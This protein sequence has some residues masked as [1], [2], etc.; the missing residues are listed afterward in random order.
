MG[1]IKYPWYGTYETK[2]RH[3]EYDMTVLMAWISRKITTKEAAKKIA[4]NNYA[5]VLKEDAF[6]EMVG[7][8]GWKRDEN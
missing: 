5:P 6:I 3:V 1:Q 8:L 2:G 7:E 4:Q